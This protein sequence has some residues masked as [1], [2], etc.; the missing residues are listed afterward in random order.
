MTGDEGSNLNKQNGLKKIQSYFTRNTL[1]S[2]TTRNQN[3]QR[4]NHRYKNLNTDRKFKINF[5]DGTP[6]ANNR[7]G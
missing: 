1:Q 3:F 7:Q 6:I 4:W 2:I 5:L